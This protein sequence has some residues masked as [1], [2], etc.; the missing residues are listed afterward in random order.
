MKRQKIQAVADTAGRSMDAGA[1]KCSRARQSVLPECS[2]RYCAGRIDLYCKSY[3]RLCQAHSLILDPQFWTN[4][5]LPLDFCLV[6]A[7]RVS[8][9]KFCSR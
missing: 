5:A 6:L 1:R 2:R 8:H 7:G 9:L 4:L 3:G